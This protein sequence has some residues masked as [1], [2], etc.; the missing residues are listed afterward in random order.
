MKLMV[1]FQENKEKSLWMMAGKPGEGVLGEG[2]P[3]EG[4]LSGLRGNK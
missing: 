4:Q 3:G 2:E 1:Q